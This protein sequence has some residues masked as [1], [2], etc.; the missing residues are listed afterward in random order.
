MGFTRK[1]K[2]LQF[3]PARSEKAKKKKKK[4]KKTS[5]TP[6]QAGIINNFFV[7]NTQIKSQKNLIEDIQ[8]FTD[9]QSLLVCRFDFE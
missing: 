1:E 3:R 6:A 4:K 2:I 9:K 8:F 7:G 5:K